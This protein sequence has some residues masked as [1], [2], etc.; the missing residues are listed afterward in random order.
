MAFSSTVNASVALP[1]FNFSGVKP[2]AVVMGEVTFPN[3]ANK[4]LFKLSF[5]KGCNVLKFVAC[6]SSTIAVDKKSVKV[7]KNNAT[8]NVKPDYDLANTGKFTLT[9]T[10]CNGCKFRYKRC[11]GS[12]QWGD[13]APQ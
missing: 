7:S 2:R 6:G 13:C 1:S 8:V 5:D 4:G 12:W 11:T 10:N 3:V 9:P